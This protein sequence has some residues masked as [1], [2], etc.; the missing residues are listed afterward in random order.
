VGS[1]VKLPYIESGLL[2]DHNPVTVVEGLQFDLYSAVAAAKQGTSAVID[3]DL[4]TGENKSFTFCKRTGE[5]S[6]LIERKQGVLEIPMHLHMAEAKGLIINE[7]KTIPT[8]HPP[9]TNTRSVPLPFAPQQPIIAQTQTGNQS[10]LASVRR[11]YTTPKS[12]RPYHVAAFWSAFDTL[13]L[14]LSKR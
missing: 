9:E 14:S 4:A 5:A 10:E 6:P 3:F 2:M 8:I 11:P 1:G 7:S 13:D 12:M